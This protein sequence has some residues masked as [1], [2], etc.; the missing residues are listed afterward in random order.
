M[1]QAFCLVGVRGGGGGGGGRLRGRRPFQES[2]ECVLGWDNEVKLGEL[3]S[4]DSWESGISEGSRSSGCGVGA[5]YKKKG[6]SCSG[7][8]QRR[9]LTSIVVVLY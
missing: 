7:V 1:W 8:L 4:C 5:L 3:S 6:I 9:L 2:Q